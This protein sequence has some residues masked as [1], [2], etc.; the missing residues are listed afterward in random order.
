MAEP[1]LLSWSRRDTYE[2]AV[3]KH[4]FGGRY[5]VDSIIVTLCVAL[6][7]YNSME[8]VL[9]ITTTFKKWKG[10]YFWSLSLC[11]LAV[12]L[13]TLGI[14]LSYFELCV[15][16][17][18]K[19]IL[20]VG[21]LGMI[22]CQA[23]VLYSRL[24]LI[25]D[26]DRL[27]AA[28][29]WMIVG[30]CMFILV[31]VI[32]LDFGSAYRPNS[33]F[34]EGYY[35]IEKIQMTIITLQELIISFL[36]VYKTLQLLRVISR[37]NTRSMIWQ[38]LFLNVIIISMDVAIVAL[39]YLQYQL[40]QETIKAF[41]YSVKLKLEIHILS[42][43]V[44]L[45]GSDRSTQRSMTLD[46]IDSNAIE[47]Q[48]QEEIRRE[49]RLSSGQQHGLGSWYGA[50]SDNEK[51][52]AVTS[53]QEDH[54]LHQDGLARKRF[55][56]SGPSKSSDG[57]DEISQIMTNQSQGTARTRGRESDFLYADML[58]SMTRDQVP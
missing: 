39:Q 47:G 19:V 18:H 53:V 13:Y 35:Y 34:T 15:Q 48:A 28:V 36:Y 2:Q 43:L 57:D 27:I 31:P 55:S 8:M 41:V 22:T 44:D 54:M 42:K 3:S 6:A 45:V 50:G 26:N 9:L 58:R 1:N 33:G 46:L 32:V 12:I 21:W 38:L 51:G 25:F 5:T 16:W 17:L 11:N 7:L 49:M 4:V 14:L 20:D 24:S 52:L 40:Y 29:K 23:L 10:L 30:T 56:T 37:A